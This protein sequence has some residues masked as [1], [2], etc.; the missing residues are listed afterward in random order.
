MPPPHRDARRILWTEGL[1]MDHGSPQI[2]VLDANPGFFC[3][4]ADVIRNAGLSVRVVCESDEALRALEQGFAP[5]AIVVRF[6]NGDGKAAELLR[7]AKNRA[8]PMISLGAPAAGVARIG[9]VPDS[10]L[11]EPFDA[12]EL[13]AMLG[14]LLRAP[15]A[16][17]ADRSP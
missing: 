16:H 13:S 14:K 8:M 7:E 9:P 2:L 12:A 5:D 3:S 11:S 1:A 4:L 15:P 17:P 6:G 10:E